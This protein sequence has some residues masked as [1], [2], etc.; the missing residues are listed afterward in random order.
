MVVIFMAAADE[1]RARHTSVKSLSDRELLETMLRLQEKIIINQQLIIANLTVKDPE[2]GDIGLASYLASGGRPRRHYPA[3]D[4]AEPAGGIEEAEPAE[5][6]HGVKE[7]GNAE[8]PPAHK[9][10]GARLTG[11]RL[12]RSM[13][14]LR[15][16]RDVKMRLKKRE[17]PEMTP[18]DRQLLGTLLGNLDEKIDE[19]RSTMKAELPSPEKEELPEKAAAE[20]AELPAENLMKPPAKAGKP[21]VFGK[22]SSLFFRKLPKYNTFTDGNFSVEYPDWVP[23]MNIHEDVILSVSRGSCGIEVSMKQLHPLTFGGYVSKIISLVKGQLKATVVEE[24][25]GTNNAYIKFEFTQGGY[26]WI[27]M[28]RVVECNASFYTVAVKV[29][30]EDLPKVESLAKYVLN[31]VG[32]AS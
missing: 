17:S 20:A 5:P 16:L 24:K 2:K 4:F 11:E 18:E 6:A 8:E 31:S 14:K 19:L 13:E 12:K 3:A 21:S 1:R 10:H 28:A 9:K 29:L 30:A 27:Y 26:K 7:A 15:S 25:T 32:C 23:D 22:I